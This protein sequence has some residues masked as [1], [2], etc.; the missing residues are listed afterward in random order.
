MAQLLCMF[1]PMVPGP[2]YPCC[3]TLKYQVLSNLLHIH[4]NIAPKLFCQA[5]RSAPGL[6][7]VGRFD[8][9]TVKRTRI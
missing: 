2:E 9:T 7:V 1:G 6:Q 5:G 4:H 3:A 8:P